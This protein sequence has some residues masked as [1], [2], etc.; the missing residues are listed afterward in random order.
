MKKL[1]WSGVIFFY[2]DSEDTLIHSL[3]FYK[4]HFFFFCF[5]L[6][7]MKILNSTWWNSSSSYLYQNNFFLLLFLDK[8]NLHDF[9]QINFI[10]LL[11][12]I[13]NFIWINCKIFWKSYL[14]F[15]ADDVLVKVSYQLTCILLKCHL[16]LDFPLC[17]VCKQI[18]L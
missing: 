14:T 9:Q 18:L 3:Y 5:C 10:N 17:H 4:H 6:A 15:E 2:R 11:S 12:S 8:L 16:N 7:P 13:K 1:F